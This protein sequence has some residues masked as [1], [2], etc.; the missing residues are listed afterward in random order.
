MDQDT[1]N[2]KEDTQSYLIKENDLKIEEL[3]NYTREKDELISHLENEEDE[4][5]D[6]VYNLNQGLL[7]NTP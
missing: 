5:E 1:D 4:L 6:K 7:G 3:E 2:I